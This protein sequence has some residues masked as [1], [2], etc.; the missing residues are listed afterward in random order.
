MPKRNKAPPLETDIA[1]LVTG[2][3]HRHGAW[4]VFSDF[5]EMA[6]TSLSLTPAEIATLQGD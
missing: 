1:K 3:A 6:A 5:C 2:L 4:Q